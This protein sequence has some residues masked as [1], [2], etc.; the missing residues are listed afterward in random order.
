MVAGGNVVA[1]QLEAHRPLPSLALCFFVS[2]CG[3]Q[4]KL[5]GVMN[6]PC[7][8]TSGEMGSA[9]GDISVRVPRGPLFAVSLSWLVYN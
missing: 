1:V 6:V 4:F 2:S 5:E 9:S 8:V 7:C 3:Y